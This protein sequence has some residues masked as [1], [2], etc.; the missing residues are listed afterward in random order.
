[1]SGPTDKFNVNSALLLIVMALSSWGLFEQNAQGKAQAA[2]AVRADAQ[3][4]ELA[5]LRVRMQANDAAI[6]DIRLTIARMPR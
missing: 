3:A 5:D 2:Y 1:M 6:Q 4:R